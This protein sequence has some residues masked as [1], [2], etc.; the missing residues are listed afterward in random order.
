[1]SGSLPPGDG[2][3]L[4][5]PFLHRGPMG[6]ADAMP[7]AGDLRGEVRPYLMT[8]GR[9]S[10]SPHV[11]VAIETIVVLSDLAHTAAPE[12]VAFERA[13]VLSQCEY[14]RSVAEVAA[15][16]GLPLRVAL[17]LV[18]DLVAEGLLVASATAARQADD[19]AFL[20]RLIDGVTAL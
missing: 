19:V 6:R 8:G 17:V 7:A 16:A 5:R 13:R 1:M 20:E 12:R 3:P 2:E 15:R 4:V 18:G 9:T 14:P 11:D 10:A